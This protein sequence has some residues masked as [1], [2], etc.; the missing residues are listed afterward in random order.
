M[1]L[2][3]AHGIRPRLVNNYAAR[4]HR[5]HSST[6]NSHL[7]TPTSAPLTPYT[8]QTFFDS[9]TATLS[10]LGG[11]CMATFVVLVVHDKR[12]RRKD[13]ELARQEVAGHR[14]LDVSES[15][16]RSAPHAARRRRLTARAGSCP[17][18]QLTRVSP[19]AT[20]RHSQ[21]Q[22]TH[23]HTCNAITRQQDVRT[24]ARRPRYA[25]AQT[26]LARRSLYGIIHGEMARYERL[27]SDFSKYSELTGEMTLGRH[28]PGSGKHAIAIAA[29]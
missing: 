28:R 17:A 2:V 14:A 3:A 8:H 27:C 11:V 13:L 26:L 24:R 9:L 5:S 15:R 10:L 25:T 6:R 29:L 4:T 7:H 21:L 16:S 18:P 23:G 22:T 1:Y 12:A 20:H 19:L